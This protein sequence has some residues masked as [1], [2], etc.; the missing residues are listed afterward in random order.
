MLSWYR[1]LRHAHVAGILDAGL[2][3]KG[4]LFYVRDFAPPAPLFGTKDMESL[5]ALLGA[6][7][8]LHRMGR[9]HGSI[10]PSNVVAS[11]KSVQLADSWIPQPWAEPSSEEEVRFSA[12]EVLKGYRR[13]IES[14][15]YSVGALL[16]RFFSGRDL[17]DD[18]DLESLK[19]RYIWASARPLTSV[20]YVSRTIADIV[21]NLIH[22]DPARRPPAFV[23][24]KNEFRVSS[25][26]AVRAPAI[27][28]SEPIEKGEQFLEKDVDRLRVLVVEAPV[29]FGKTRYIEELRH[30]MALRAP[31]RA[32]SVCPT[33]G[34]WPDV[35][36]AQ[37]LLSVFERRCADFEDPSVRRL[38]AL[39][40]SGL[41]SV[42]E[43]GAERI[44]HDLIEVIASI[45]QKE[46]LILVIEDI[47]RAN[48][49]L[50]PLIDSIV[51]R[52]TRLRLC[53]VVTSR[54]GGIPRKT[55]QTCRDFAGPALEYIPLCA[56]SDTDAE[57]V[58]SFL[59]RDNDRRSVARQKAGGNPLFLEEYCKSQKPG[60]P[61]VVRSTISKLISALPKQSRRVA[62][63]LSLFEEPVSLEVLRQITTMPDADLEADLSHLQKLGLIDDSVMIRHTD[64][65]AF[66]HSRISKSRKTELHAQAYEHLKSSGAD[67]KNLARHAYL[68]ELYKAAGEMYLELASKAFHSQAF[69]SAAGFY[70]LLQ[71]CRELHSTVPQA[72]IEEVISF[73]K[74]RAYV[75]HTSFARAALE[76]LLAVQA[77][78]ADPELLSSVYAAL[79]SPFIEPSN[80][81]RVRLL[82]LA[83]LSLNTD[84]PT[85][86]Y[87][88]GSLA[89]ALLGLGKFDEAEMALES[90]L[91]RHEEG[92]DSE[93]CIEMRTVILMN[94]GRFS[95]AANSFSSKRF[96]WAVPLSVTLNIVVCL[97][98]IGSIHEARR[99]QTNALREAASQG[100]YLEVLCL[101]NLASMESKL[102][103]TSVAQNLFDSA[104]T[105]FERMHQRQLA[106]YLPSSACYSDAALHAIQLGN[107]RKALYCVTRLNPSP[108]R[109]SGL[110]TFQF[111]LSRGELY[112]ALG[113]F[114]ALAAIL[115][116]TQEFVRYGE[117]FEVEQLL[118]RVR[119]HESSE[120]LCAELRQALQ[121]S[122]RLETR[123][124][125]CRVLIALAN[126][127]SL[128]G[129]LPSARNAL[130][131]ALDLALKG[132]YRLLSAQALMRR[133]LAA[134]NDSQK[135]SDWMQ[136]LQ[137]ASRM[138]LYPLLAECAFHM[139]AWRACC[140]D[141]PAARD[142]LF[143][144]VSITARLAQDL[145]TT[146]RKRFLSLPLHREARKL[147]EDATTRTTE[148]HSVLKEPLGKAELFFC[149]VYRLTCSLKSA[150]DLTS[151]VSSL[152]HAIKL[153]IQP[154]G[155][156]VL[157]SGRDLTL[158]P[159][160]ESCP[161]DLKQRAK[162]AFGR[163]ETH[164]YFTNLGKRDRQGSAVW[165]PIQS[166]SLRAG[167][168][169][170]CPDEA[171][172]LDEQEIRFL[173]VSAAIVGA[174]LD[175]KLG[176]REDATTNRPR[177]FSGI[178]GTS[179]PMKK[180][181]A[182]I[183]NAARNAATVLIEGESGTGKELVAKAIHSRSLRADAPFIPV[184][185]GALPEGLI[186]AELF[187]IK[188]GSF[189]GAVEDR[190]GLFEGADGGTIFLDE[191][192]NASLT[193]QTKLLRVLQEREIRR[194]G[195]TKRKRID[196]RLIAATNCNLEKLVEEGKFRQD[197]LFR[198]K[199]LHIELPPLRERK[200]D[201]ALLA[202]T[203]LNRLNALNDTTVSFGTAALKEL[204][205][206]EYRGNVR[207]LQ[208]IVERCFYGTDGHVITKIAPHKPPISNA[209]SNE[210]E[211]W[212][213]DLTEGRRNFW[214]AVRDR[215][216]RRDISRERVL[217]LLDFGLRSTQGNYKA[218]ASMFKIKDEEYRRFMDFLRRN[219][220]LLDF[221]PYRRVETRS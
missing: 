147:L 40:D 211:G 113:Q 115:D 10:K 6:V 186:E 67:L 21:E 60:V 135:Q 68:G 87:R 196:V 192:A 110:E 102:G 54:P 154:I 105:K 169:I 61:P 62:E 94:R 15:L 175:Q 217:A 146:D 137:E 41:E 172:M 112:L 98:Q 162:S 139:G 57:S 75:G 93:R 84:S 35:A 77:V 145:S 189:T 103:N 36:V 138:G 44:T 108:D 219:D 16:Y 121:L 51:S 17:F 52:A 27:G 204:L 37:W 8:F 199:V 168:Y 201:I 109:G 100:T 120:A 24:L 184:D 218:V 197:L 205:S 209:D 31:N 144:S 58:A 29:G 1:G 173:T 56:L 106:G 43:Y 155:I 111:L 118:L 176:K 89:N 152:A 117:F 92:P 150:A 122:I 3:S 47:D 25:A 38:Q 22:K 30:R 149:S 26:A 129:D 34:R 39:V 23:A 182:E 46:P 156:V 216:K 166:L 86:A 202:T 130:T 91:S 187:G 140:G 177:E 191:V 114:G 203:F 32:F 193:L 212:F 9:V 50:C 28:M 88:Y 206:Y 143:R 14:D 53:V 160:S 161:E 128:Q 45:A 97:E 78:H 171:A 5:N 180:V 66:L 163:T 12:P 74:C 101:G 215:Y 104:I 208:N 132:Q 165:V 183:E 83:I 151:M 71:N 4:D 69:R 195:D 214:S 153:C 33:L 72:S 142:Y 7:D 79:A 194:L 20:S 181:Y 99:I 59:E 119:L 200:E 164:L 157:G 124:Q 207:E 134:E 63:V 13:T 178:V 179:K 167:I 131:E 95:E 18:G 55:L 64:S 127:L 82:N 213:R 136:C 185:C 19:A 220:C 133:G 76:P 2:T 42:P 123:Y 159:L 48:R 210:T 126:N 85:L 70:E 73:A 190:R 198:L 158:Y 81:E 141:Y 170:E 90:A 188:K 148:F 221:R 11:S 65:R 174:A 96:R 125:E 116:K 107:Y 80:A 49:K